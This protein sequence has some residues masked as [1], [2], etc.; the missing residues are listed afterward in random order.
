MGRNEWKGEGGRVRRRVGK[1]EKGFDLD[2]CTGPRVPSHATG[3]PPPST[4]ASCCVRWCCDMGIHA[5]R[6]CLVMGASEPTSQSD[7]Q[8]VHGSALKHIH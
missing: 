4:R 7:D 1:G 6:R 2:I 3:R 8:R 5:F